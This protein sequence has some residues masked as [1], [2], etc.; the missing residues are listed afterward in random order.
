MTIVTLQS[1]AGNSPYDTN[2]PFKQDLFQR[3]TPGKE[4]AL[5]E[6]KN[7]DN[8]FINY[9]LGMHILEVYRMTFRMAGCPVG[10]PSS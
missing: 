2:P 3:V 10:C 9:E 5:Y 7:P 4:A 6:P 1:D 8:I